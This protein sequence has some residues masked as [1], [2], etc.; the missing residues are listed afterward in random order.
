MDESP[1]L[2]VGLGEGLMDLDYIVTRVKEE[3]P[4]ANLIFEGVPKD[5]MESS[6][7]YINSILNK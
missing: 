6:I 1:L 5:K 7:K 4:H 3:I 2:K